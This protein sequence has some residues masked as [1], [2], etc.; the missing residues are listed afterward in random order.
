[1][2]DATGLEL[3]FFHTEYFYP[4]TLDILH[5]KDNAISVAYTLLM[6]LNITVF[7][8]K[9]NHAIIFFFIGLSNL[10]IFNVRSAARETI[11]SNNHLNNSIIVQQI[12]RHYKMVSHIY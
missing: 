2:R 11:R 8:I 12:K 6:K 1:M 5:C 4:A 7:N 10:N 3:K 9:K